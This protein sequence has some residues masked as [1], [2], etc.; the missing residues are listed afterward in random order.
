MLKWFRKIF[1]S[2]EKYRIEYHRVSPMAI[3]V[4]IFITLAMLVIV[5]WFTEIIRD[6]MMQYNR[7]VMNTYARLWSMTLS[8]SIEGPELSIL[9]EEIIQKADFPMVYTN[10]D[11]E[12]I[13]WRNLSVAENDTSI[14]ARTKVKKWLARHGK[15]FPPIAVRIPGKNEV[16]A[17]I[18]FGESPVVEWL[19]FIPIAQAFVMLVLFIL[20]TIIYKRIKSYEQQN[21]WLGL[22]KEAAHQL[23]TPTSSL[24]GWIELTR[25]CLEEKDYDEIERIVGEMEKDIRNLSKIVVRF[26]QIGSI[27]ELSPLDPILF[28]REITAYFKKRLPQF[29][30]NIELIEHYEP[31]PMIMANKLLISWA[32]ENLI[33]NSVEAIGQKKDGIIWVSIR[34][35]I[36]GK[37]VNIAVSDNGKGIPSTHQKKIFSPGFT[38]KKRGWGLGLSLAKRIVEDYHHGKLYLLES[39]PNEKTTFVIALP[40]AGEKH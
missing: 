22:A 19:V 4:M 17:Y 16:L 15:K 7:R 36:D 31:V 37:E 38:S 25:E 39:R 27:P 20:G 26:G 28:S 14:S 12:P 24:L 32:L 10:A 30:K 13:Y 5:F 40:A 18:Y 34:P 23:G 29:S 8:R 2:G 9:F 3:S 1:S 21:I 35:N 6:K 11:K 33:K